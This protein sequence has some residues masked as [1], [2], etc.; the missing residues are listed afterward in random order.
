M[1][2]GVKYSEGGCGAKFSWVHYISP[3]TQI[4]LFQIGIGLT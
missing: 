1:R 3:F 2:G 4:T